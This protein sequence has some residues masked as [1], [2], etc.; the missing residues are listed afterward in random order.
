MFVIFWILST[1]YI[2]RAEPYKTF[3]V[4]APVGFNRWIQ[5]LLEAERRE[6]ER[7]EA[8]RLEAER[9]ETERLEAS[10]L[11]AERREAKQNAWLCCLLHAWMNGLNA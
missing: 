1:F 11:E 8:E 5:S 10:R 4:L 2:F 9:R 7:I 3:F 6:A